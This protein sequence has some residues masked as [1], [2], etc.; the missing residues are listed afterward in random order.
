MSLTALKD[1]AML[2]LM[3]LVCAPC[4]NF[5]HGGRGMKVVGELCPNDG[6]YTQLPNLLMF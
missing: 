6:V 4:C 5:Q 3:H 2:S 1:K